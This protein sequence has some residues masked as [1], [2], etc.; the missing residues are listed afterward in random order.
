[1][2]KNYI[3]Y[4]F[5]LFYISAFPQGE[6][7]IWYFGVNAGLDFNNNPPTPLLDL[8][9]GSTFSS[10]GCSTISDS[11]GVLLFFTNG[12]KVWNKNHQIMLNGDDLA[13]HNSSTQS[14]A[15]IP[16]PGTY[17]F[18]KNRF[19][20]YFLVTLDDYIAQSPS[21][22]KKGVCYSE[23]DMTMDNELGAVTTNKN[24]HLFGT[25]TTE[26]VCVVPH[27][28]GCDY[29]VICKVVDSPDFYVYH[30]SNSGFNTTPIIS[31]TNFFVDAK[32]GQMKVS[33]NNKLLSYAVPTSSTY[34]GLYVFNF[35]NSTGLI[36]EKFADNMVN[37]S[38]YGTAFSPNSEVLYKC[39][40]SKIYQ[41]DVTTTTN[42]AFVA[43]KL[44]FT[45]TVSG[46]QSMQL[47][48]DGKIYIAR[49]ILSSSQGGIGV[50]NNPNV[51]GQGCNYVPNQQSLGGK[52][53]L[54]GLPN[55][56]N[57]IK[58]HNTIIIQNQ[59]C[60]SLQLMMANNNNIYS[61]NWELAYTA[62]PLTPISTS[63]DANPLFNI[64]NPN[65]EYL[66]TCIIVTHCY[67]YTYKL[68]FTPNNLNYSTPTFTLLTNTYCQG[69][70]PAVLPL[71]SENGITG[72]WLPT[73]IDTATAGVFTYTFTPDVIQCANPINV[74]ITIK[75][76]VSVNFT[77]TTIC[78][79]ESLNFPNTNNIS[80]NW[81]PA[82]V[83]N[84]SSNTYIFT[85]NG[86]CA[87]ST[88]W[89]VVVNEKTQVSFNN[90]TF[91]YGK[92]INFPNTNG[93]NG[94]WFPANLSNTQSS[95][96]TFTPNGNCVQ[97]TTWQVIILESFTNLTI[98]ILDN[99]SI[100]VNVENANNSILYQLDNGSFQD[101]NVFNNV[102][103][104]CHT[105]N[106]IDSNGCTTLTSSA[107]VFDYPI[108]FTPNEDGH[109]DYWTIILE[110]TKT[111]LYIFD[112]YGKLLKQIRQ[113]EKGWDG[114]YNGEKLPSTDYWFVL[115]YE[116]CGFSK[117]FKSHFSLKR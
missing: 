63:V 37:D 30:I 103:P 56:L 66:I 45:S 55:Q 70:T 113:N 72:T 84:T 67:S 110:N 38:Q 7:N 87:T 32:P 57:N 22:I 111:N 73:A 54:A 68:A 48:P 51:L 50:I 43:S 27:S 47:A 14:S 25:T 102:S 61:Y 117:T 18:T 29:W 106:V 49:P 31:T 26:K 64:P 99:K 23:I 33:P 112:R 16:Y 85:P 101:S 59:D 90:S 1:M 35:D 3:V 115:E 97:Q 10:E 96:Y 53:C 76:S 62:N 86:E 81:F 88:Q 77:P 40:G 9:I 71:T 78:V 13:G 109:N 94:T 100:V 75:P 44:M 52:S 80:G 98:S 24:I 105:V 114:F 6:A 95:I 92:T 58:P 15:I 60:N 34:A 89:T 104:G 41:Y 2:I 19:D 39:S 93:V 20:K 79:G 46:L 83:S 8:N 65:A 17:D 91:C 11:N 5:L 4:F 108:F 42:G 69:Q 82:S 28:N 21:I 36:T 12:E 74:S 116:G 107:F